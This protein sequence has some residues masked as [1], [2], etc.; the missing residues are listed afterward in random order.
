MRTNKIFFLFTT[1]FTSPVFFFYTALL[2]IDRSFESL[3]SLIFAAGVLITVNLVLS[4]HDRLKHLQEI[5]ENVLGKYPNAKFTMIGVKELIPL[6]HV[7]N[8]FERNYASGML[9]ELG[10]DINSISSLDRIK[11]VKVND[12]GKPFSNIACFYNMQN[13]AFI[14]VPNTTLQDDALG[15]YIIY[16]EIAHSAFM[17]RKREIEFRSIQMQIFLLAM[18]IP[19]H[20]SWNIVSCF[21]YFMFLLLASEFAGKHYEKKKIKSKIHAELYADQIALDIMKEDDKKELRTILR[22]GLGRGRL[23]LY[24][25]SMEYPANIMRI[26]KLANLNR[27]SLESK[28]M[29]GSIENELEVNEAGYPVTSTLWF[30]LFLIVLALNSSTVSFY[31]GLGLGVVILI[32]VASSLSTRKEWILVL[33][34]IL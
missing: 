34:Q 26:A 16:H 7:L 25:D 32:G 22:K 20:L 23:V 6:Q 13:E 21:L 27:G 1:V 29:E 24:D 15:N 10:V 31:H 30:F 4:Q 18:I 9:E 5:L 17:P 3:L 19:F 28:Q 2:F 11:V 8:Y 14:F 33:C 12:D